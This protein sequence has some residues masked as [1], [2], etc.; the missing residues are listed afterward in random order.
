VELKLSQTVIDIGS[1]TGF[2]L[3]ELAERLGTTSKLYGIDP[4]MNANTRARQKIKTYK[5]SNVEIIEGSAEKIPFDDHSI[6]LIVS[7]L[8]LNNFENPAVIFRECH[9]VLKPKGK[10]ALTSNLN[11][12]WREFYGI[13]YATLKELGKNHFIPLLQTEETHR[14]TVES[15]SGLFTDN[16][17]KVSRHFTECHE[18]KFVD[19]STFLNHHFVK[20]GW[21]Q[22]WLKLFPKNELEEI[23]CALEKNLNAYADKNGGLNLSVPMIYIEG[24][25]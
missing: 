1:G 25:S 20:M 16:G 18:M 2:P 12:H 22:G 17:L 8:G 13:F 23:F 3:I 6:D 11:G 7:N 24:K 21:L 10:L 19:G 15:I 14:G 4:W 5:L 9:R